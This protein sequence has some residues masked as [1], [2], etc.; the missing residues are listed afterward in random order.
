MDALAATTTSPGSS[1][2]GFVIFPWAPVTPH[3]GTFANTAG[4]MIPK[5]V[6][7]YQFVSTG[8][9]IFDTVQDLYSN[10]YSMY[11]F[12]RGSMRIKLFVKTKGT[13]YDPTFPIYVYINNVALPFAGYYSPSMGGTVAQSAGASDQL[14][15]GPLQVLYDVPVT[16]TTGTKVGFTYQPGFAEARLA[17]IPTLEGCVE[18][19]VPYHASGHM[20]PT[21]YG[22]YTP[23]NARSIFYPIP[24]ITVTG[25]N[26]IGG[27]APTLL[28]SQV[29]VFR[30]V[31]DDFSFGG[32]LGTPKHA[33]WYSGVDPV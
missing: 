32:L 16:T 25:S 10:I 12:F 11:A 20:C 3:N 31:G 7:R 24:T 19:E 26:N 15:T 6:S 2:N 27:T 1:G 9:Q 18:F 13:N 17:L 21:T 33:V 14:G 8:T 4:V 29:D 23:T 5:Y 30:A 22:Q 28:L